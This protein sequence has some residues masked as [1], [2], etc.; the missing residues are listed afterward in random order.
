MGVHALIQ[1]CMIANKI[2]KIPQNTQVK[3]YNIRG[4]VFLFFRIVFQSIPIEKM[5]GITV[6]V[7][8]Q[9]AVNEVDQN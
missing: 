5:N 8:V 3:K 9:E 1:I 2:K 7:T 4:K 6:T